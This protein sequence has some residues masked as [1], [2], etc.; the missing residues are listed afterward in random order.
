MRRTALLRGMP[1]GTAVGVSV[2]AISSLAGARK[3][4]GEHMKKMIGEK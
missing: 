3:S 2:L 4:Y 1:S